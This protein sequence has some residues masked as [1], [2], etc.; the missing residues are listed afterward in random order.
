MVVKIAVIAIVCSLLVMYLKNLKAEYGQLLLL[1]VGVVLSFFA[2]AYLKNMAELLEELTGKITLP[3]S[4][5][6]V[7]L[8]MIGIAYVCEFAS[9]LC[10]DAGCQT[11]AGQVEMIGKLSMLFIST[12]I[13]TALIEMI[14]NLV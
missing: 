8:K 6:T 3:K 2:F 14:G 9:N 10:K 4:Y 7:L 5:L 13:V 1:A 11:I 12:P